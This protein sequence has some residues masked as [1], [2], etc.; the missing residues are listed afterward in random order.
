MC[1]W[2]IVYIL[3]LYSQ[4][5]V[6]END[7]VAE[8]YDIQAMPTFIIFQNKQKLERS[9]GADIDKVKEMIKKYQK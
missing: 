4:V 2:F 5:D 8:K 3:Y 9:R 1:V 6:D 7:D